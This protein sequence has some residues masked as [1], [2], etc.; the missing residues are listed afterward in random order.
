[1]ADDSELEEGEVPEEGEMPAGPEDVAPP[2]SAARAAPARPGRSPGRGA[3]RSHQ[4]LEQEH[5]NGGN[6][7]LPR[8]APPRSS[9]R[10][11]SGGGGSEARAP[12]EAAQ[13]AARARLLRERADLEAELRKLTGCL[14]FMEVRDGFDTACAN[15]RAAL[16]AL[17]RLLRRVKVRERRGPFLHGASSS[18]RPGHAGT[19]I[20]GPGTHAP[21]TCGITACSS[22][23]VAAREIE[24]LRLSRR[25]RMRGPRRTRCASN[26]SRMPCNYRCSATS[27]TTLAST[28]AV[29]S[30]H[31]ASLRA[32]STSCCS[33]TPGG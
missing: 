18:S 7:S 29:L 16:K 8:G 27:A 4:Q 13:R 1:M 5:K 14:A 23:P 30:P 12:D 9:D 20:A 21:G 19:P 33:A 10:R 17:D 32:S 6:G 15:M 24:S 22:Q 11:G 26:A 31:T 25:C 3:P 28:P 2:S